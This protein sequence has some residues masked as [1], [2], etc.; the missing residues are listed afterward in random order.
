MITH[1]TGR[2]P[3]ILAGAAAVA[4]ALSGQLLASPA[5]AEGEPVPTDPPVVVDA[6][7]AE[8]PAETPAPEPSPEAEPAAEPE[9]TV[10]PAPTADPADPAPAAAALDDGR[11]ELRWSDRSAQVPGAAGTRVLVR[12]GDEETVLAEHDLADAEPGAE[13][14]DEDLAPV[15]EPTGEPLA[16]GELA[17]AIGGLRAA[18]DYRFS[19]AVLGADETVLAESERTEPLR[20]AAAPPAEPA[21][22]PP[23]EEESDGP[24]ASVPASGAGEDRSEG[25]PAGAGTD[26]DAVAADSDPVRGERPAADLIGDFLSTGRAAPLGALSALAASAPAP[27]VAVRGGTAI[28]VNFA[29]VKAAATAVMA[30]PLTLTI[31]VYDEAETVVKTQAFYFTPTFGDTGLITGLAA[32]TSYTV[33]AEVSGYDADF[34]P[35]API[36]SERSAPFTTRATSEAPGVIPDLPILEPTSG[37]SIQVSWAPVVDGGDVRTYTVRLYDTAGT[38]VQTKTGLNPFADGTSWTFTGLTALTGYQ[39]TVQAIGWET[40]T[41][42]VNGA[43]S[44]L[45]Q[46]GYTLRGAPTKPGA[47]TIA[48]IGAGTTDLVV[49]WSAPTSDGGYPVTA[50]DLQIFAGT[51]SSVNLNSIVRTVRV[52]GTQTSWT[53]PQATL[54]GTNLFA[55]VAAVNEAGSSAY[56]LQATSSTNV[57]ATASPSTAVTVTSTNVQFTDITATGATIS[58]PVQTG[59]NAPLAGTGYLLRVTEQRPGITGQSPLTYLPPSAPEEAPIGQVNAYGIIDLGTGFTTSGRQSAAISGLEPG[60]S[61]RVTITQYLGDGPD[62]TYRSSS[63]VSAALLTTTGTSVPSVPAGTPAAPKGEGIDTLSWSG[64]A[65]TGAYTGGSAIVGYRVALY[66]SGA[67]APMRV[68]DAEIDD[69]GRP[70]VLIGG[71]ERGAPYQIAYAGVNANGVGGFSAIGDV[72]YTLARPAPGTL[73]PPYADLAALN[74]GIAAAEVTEVTAASAGVTT[75]FESG[76]E[77]TVTPAYP[78]EE[79]GEVWLYAASGAPVH[80]ATYTAA[81][82]K[83]PATWTLGSLETGTY[84]LLYFG[85]GGTLVAVEVPVTKPVIGRTDLDDAVFRWGIN[86]ESSNGAYFGGCNYLTAGKVNNPGA[87]VVFGSAAASGYRSEDG[88]VTVVKP[89]AAGEYQPATWENKCKTRS[90]TTVTTSVTSAFTEQQLV[91]TGGEGWVDPSTNSGELQWDGDFT[92]VF[93]GGLTFWYGSDPKLTVEHGVGTVTA[94]LGGYGS[95][96]DD[97]SKWTTLEDR[98]VTLATLTGVR[99]TSKGFTVT[100]DYLGVAID[101]EGAREGQPAKTA[102]NVAYWGSFPQDF[103]EFQKLTGQSSYWFTSGGAQDRSKPTLPLTVVYSSLLDE[104]GAGE[105]GG[106]GVSVT[107]PEVQAP[108]P[109]QS[110]LRGPLLATAQTTPVDGVE[111]LLALIEEGAVTRLAPEQVGLKPSFAIGERLDLRFAWS[112]ADT[113]G[114]VWLYPGPAYVGTFRVVGGQVSI[115]IDSRVVAAEGPVY[116]VFFGDAGTVMAVES[117]AAGFAAAEEEESAPVEVRPIAAAADESLTGS[118]AP[119]GEGVPQVAL[120]ALIAGGGVVTLGAA[121]GATALLIRRRGIG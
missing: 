81:G 118:G 2:A 120:I 53:F 63:G 26:E 96:M 5:F 85:D 65:L 42:F 33:E 97:L 93:Y 59:A 80:Q 36:V 102:D 54:I 76:T 111:S 50:Y 31:R 94:T 51:T 79:Q 90:G 116:L 87:A 77:A 45:S 34:N 46:V 62:R 48:A 86:N 109:A 7:A 28:E 55:R 67:S 14:P 101:S 30:S 112:G 74:A 38:L 20:T 41:A 11:V 70:T 98:T 13:E 21:P 22:V 17:V 32:G 10:E 121:G 92:V 72:G 89:N 24:D 35:L 107:P 18:T 114:V 60:R 95:D 73:P 115:A 25:G 56:S 61:Y 88:N 16:E 9:P 52:P 37:S 113:S 58:W 47:P 82:G 29:A 103:V 40:G 39:A 27:T 78:V 66:R 44:A 43:E 6:P 110:A 19:V 105:G 3:K 49:T 68:V 1:R 83:A 71:L 104:S 100:P 15:T 8:A 117:A 69:D 91:I 64:P 57:P 99:M 75:A 108:P 23:E 119:A 4:I 84:T 106:E 12:L